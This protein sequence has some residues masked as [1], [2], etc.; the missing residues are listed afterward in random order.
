VII[1]PNYGTKTYEETDGFKIYRFPFY[2]KL[3]E[4]QNLPGTFYYTNPIWFLWL[5]W[6][7]Y[8]FVKKNK[9][10]IIHV[11]G[12]FSVPSACFANL[13]LG[14][15]ILATIRDYQPICNYGFCLYKKE[16]ACNLKEYFFSDF[17]YYINH[18]LKTKNYISI[19]TN[20]IFAIWGRIA[21]NGLRFFSQNIP[22]VVL[23]QKQKEIFINNGFNKV[24]VIGNPIDFPNTIRITNKQNI[25]IF[26]GRLTPGKG[27]DLLI[28][29]LPKFF[30]NFPSYK[31]IFAGEGFYKNELTKLSFKE[32]RI[33]VLG[34]VDH[35]KLLRI[36]IKA[37]AVIA[38]S[39]WPEPFGRIV[40]EAISRGTP[41]VVS[42]RG[43]LPEIV[44]DKR[45]GFVVFP[46]TNNLE[47]AI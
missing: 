35:K 2:K 29:I 8:K 26:A 41:V 21:R 23:S 45:W 47:S 11:H 25:I 14:K 43:G 5:S 36:L 31:F 16:K 15:C 39:I 27:V 24:K 37:K 9:I 10:D 12:K 17:K 20:F 3:K 7:I 44:K 33:K 22:I 1:T 19:F 46:T 4:K 42:N 38:P 28:K 40:L 32:K 30:S 13:F 34:Q 18:Y 6:H